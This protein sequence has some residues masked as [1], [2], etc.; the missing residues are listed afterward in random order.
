MLTTVFLFLAMCETHLNAPLYCCEEVRPSKYIHTAAARPLG[1]PAVIII[2]EAHTMLHR[3]SFYTNNLDRMLVHSF[4]DPVPG[5]SIFYLRLSIKIITSGAYFWLQKARELILFTAALSGF[6][7]VVDVCQPRSQINALSIGQKYFAAALSDT[8][9]QKISRRRC[10]E[11]TF[12]L[13]K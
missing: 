2:S 1:P 7:V 10:A 4:Y 9:E 8:N 5:V 3:T 13:R 11:T 12:L 6:L